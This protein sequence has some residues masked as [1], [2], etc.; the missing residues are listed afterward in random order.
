[1]A[2]RE[3]NREFYGRIVEQMQILIADGRVPVSAAEL[4]QIRLDGYYMED[5]YVTGDAVV[6]YRSMVKIVLDSQTLREITPESELINGALVLTEEDYNAL[7]GEE[8]KRRE[9]GRLNCGLSLDEVIANPVWNALARGDRGLV[10][11]YAGS[12][13]SERQRLGYDGGA[14]GVYLDSAGDK[15]KLRAWGI[16]D[17]R[18]G[19]FALGRRGLDFISG[20]LLGIY[21]I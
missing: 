4:M 17:L 5:Y 2:L 11:D 6:Y 16:S 7:Q 13:F 21:K 9:L 8:F 12:I 20:R 18:D 19:S 3:A 1:M 14:M 10:R 15:V